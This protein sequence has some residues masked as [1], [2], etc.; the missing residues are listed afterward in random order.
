MMSP[1]N[2]GVLIR[3]KPVSSCIT[4]R[5]NCTANGVPANGSYQE[6]TGGQ[7]GV[8]TG[9]NDA[10]KPETSRTWLFGAVYA[11]G[12]ARSSGFAS[13]LSIEG[14][15]YDIKVDDAIAPVD[16]QLT[17][18]RCAQA[19]DA[20]SCA[21]ITR[22]PSGLISRIN[23]QL[24]NIGGIR[25][26]GV[27][28]TAVYRS[29]QTGAG[30]FGLSL[31]G[32]ILLKYSET[33]PASVGFTTTDYASK[34]RGFPDQSYPKF[35]GNAVVDWDLGTARASFTGRYINHV[36]EADGAKLKNTFYGD[37]QLTLAPGWLENRL[38]LTIGVNNVFNQD[39]PAC[40]SCTLPN[41]DPTTYDVPGQF[42][43]VRLSWG[44]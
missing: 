16:A 3:I 28:V 35:K 21:A 2:S 32:N 4:V 36:R 12:W 38:G 41:Y 13:Q 22:T 20:L 25:T 30:I 43:Y 5:A 23:A 27:D 34:T 8:L 40:T 7:L 17:L 37:V 15:Y 42:G 11:P 39:P 14:N 44:L 10:L 29:P 19:A 31:N 6:P 18:S 9:G 33:F 24:Q 1:C 26:R